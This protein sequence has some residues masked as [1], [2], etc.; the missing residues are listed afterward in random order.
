MIPLRGTNVQTKQ[1]RPPD[2][3]FVLFSGVPWIS[4]DAALQEQIQSCGYAS[5]VSG[6]LLTLVTASF[7]S[8][9]A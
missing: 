5:R 2:I 7:V 1:D 3:P 6:M 8:G 9:T 4:A